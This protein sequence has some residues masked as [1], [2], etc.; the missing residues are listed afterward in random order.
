MIEL[1]TC[2]V[3]YFLATFV[4]D[5]L[6]LVFML[7]LASVLILIFVI[8]LEHQIIP[9][10]LVFSGIAAI[11]LKLILV[12]NVR[13]YQALLAGFVAALFLL[14]INLI[15]RGRGM[16]LGDV[17]FAVLGG[18]FLGFKLV[19]IWFFISF[20][21]GAFVG[22]ILVLLKTSKLKDKIAFGP[23]LIAGLVATYIWGNPI[24][25]Y[26]FVAR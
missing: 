20:L 11:L 12:D 3:F 4:N 6:S 22:I 16:G 13:I 15:T 21:S 2:L 18:L 14:L 7:F 23:F 5:P 24:Y 19:F 17:K 1:S 8:D 25:N 9:D 10:T 26:L